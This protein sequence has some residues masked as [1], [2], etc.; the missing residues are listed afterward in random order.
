[1]KTAPNEAPGVVWALAI[2]I[3]IFSVASLI[4]YD[5]ARKNSCSLRATQNFFMRNSF[6][7]VINMLDPNEF[8]IQFDWQIVSFHPIAKRP[9]LSNG[10]AAPFKGICIVTE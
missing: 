2:F 8:L 3:F 1:V 9:L 4:S 7:R 5:N 6:I 10:L